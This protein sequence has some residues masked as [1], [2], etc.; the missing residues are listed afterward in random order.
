MINNIRKCVFG[1]IFFVLV[2]LVVLQSYLIDD[3][4]VSVYIHKSLSDG[5]RS[6][7]RTATLFV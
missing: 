2:L 4:G 1:V 7:K 6:S 5:G 3:V